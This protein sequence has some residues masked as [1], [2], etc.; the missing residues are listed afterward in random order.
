MKTRSKSFLVLLALLMFA[1]T[2]D[3]NQADKLKELESLEK[4]RRLLDKK[5]RLL[6]EELDY[7][8]VGI[9]L[10]QVRLMQ[11]A[12]ADFIK[13]LDVNGFVEAIKQ[14]SLSSETRGKLQEVFIEEGAKVFK[15]DLLAKLNTSVIDNTIEEVKANLLLAI[16][17]FEKQS[18]LWQKEIGSE[19]QFLESKAKKE[20]LEKRLEA[21]KSQRD[22]HD[23]RA[24]FDGVIDIIYT[25]E[26]EVLTPGAPFA[27][28]VQL[29]QVYAVVDVSEKYITKIRKQ[30]K[31]RVSFPSLQ[32][33]HKEARVLRISNLINK[34]NRTFRVEVMLNNADHNIKPNMMTVLSFEEARVKE[35]ISIPNKAVQKDMK[36]YF[37]YKTES[38]EKGNV[39]IKQYV[40]IGLSNNLFMLIEEGVS[41]G[42]KVVVDGY[43]QVSDGSYVEVVQ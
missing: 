6:K 18:R 11:A 1:C 43:N 21:L 38:S 4:E 13:T 32:I 2:A 19:V 42:E 12:R 30:D 8:Q 9:S 27:E 33:K 15:G 39:V 26:G 23:V 10:P 14:A 17:V 29:D 20:S 22:L 28:L 7:K 36:G 37:V 16:T 41:V 25:K 24:S 31:V 5:I 34:K 3:Q 40:K 35:S